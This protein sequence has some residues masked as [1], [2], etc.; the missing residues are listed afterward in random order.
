MR[1]RWFDR[2]DPVYLKY[3]G[4][5]EWKAR[6]QQVIVRCDGRCERCGELPAYEVHHL[7]YERVF[8]ELPEDLQGLCEFCHDFVHGKRLDDGTA[9]ARRQ[10][11]RQAE[12]E[13]QV[14]LA[15]Q[16]LDRVDQHA[17]LYRII[18]AAEFA[19]PQDLVVF[20]QSRS[21]LIGP[22]ESEIFD[23]KYARWRKQPTVT[24]KIR[25]HHEG[26][27]C[28][29]NPQAVDDFLW[30]GRYVFDA[31]REVWVDLESLKSFVRRFSRRMERE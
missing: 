5:K 28:F 14:R 17:N 1:G 2:A 12:L 4:S 16:E 20:L 15:R 21:R 30:N 7:T 9:E 8:H 23:V 3:L 22:R 6:R 19:T 26:S 31:D 29:S 25:W 13:D 18:K 27:L 10:A 11:A 24:F